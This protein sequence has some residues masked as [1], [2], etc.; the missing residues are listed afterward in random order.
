MEL[1]HIPLDNYLYFFLNYPYKIPLDHALESAFELYPIVPIMGFV[2]KN[3][4]WEVQTV[5]CIPDDRT[6]YKREL[7]EQRVFTDCGNRINVDAVREIIRNIRHV[8]L[9]PQQ[10]FRELRQKVQRIQSDGKYAFRY[11][12]Q[13]ISGAI[14][15][16]TIVV[17]D[18]N[19]YDM[20][21]CFQELNRDA[22]CVNMISPIANN[23]KTMKNQLVCMTRRLQSLL[24]KQSDTFS[25]PSSDSELVF[26]HSD[27]DEYKRIEKKPKRRWK[28]VKNKHKIVVKG[29]LPVE[30]Y[31]FC[32][33]QGYEFQDN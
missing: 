6:G 25:E 15:T 9:V 5:L 12:F 10:L 13:V 7:F 20:T 28:F 30:I 33:E 8:E 4:K 22:N 31:K 3:N 16:A 17:D 19:T 23:E 1:E 18:T 21:K 2:L 29:E 11:I 24:T 14:A 27:E 26:S 32:K